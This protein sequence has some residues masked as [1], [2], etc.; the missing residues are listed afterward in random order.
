LAFQLQ[1]LRLK[2]HRQKSHVKQEMRLV[3]NR[4]NWVHLNCVVLL[5]PT[6]GLRW[7]VTENAQIIEASDP[8]VRNLETTVIRKH[9]NSMKYSCFFKKINNIKHEISI[10]KKPSF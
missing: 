6:G 2:P 9:N 5:V 4:L 10:Y 8:F 3:L 1:F 7:M